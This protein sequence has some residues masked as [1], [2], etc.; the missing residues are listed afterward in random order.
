MWHETEQWFAEEETLCGME[1]SIGYVNMDCLRQQIM[2]VKRKAVMVIQSIL[3][4]GSSW[5][6]IQKTFTIDSVKV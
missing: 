5:T 2:E 1:Q 6:L 3:A 4:T